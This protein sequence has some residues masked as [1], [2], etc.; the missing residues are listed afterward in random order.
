MLCLAQ[1]KCNTTIISNRKDVLGNHPNLRFFGTDLNEAGSV[2]LLGITISKDLS[3]N[4]VINRMA[5]SAGQRLGLL[6][7]TAPYLSPPQRATIYKSMVRSKMEYAST[8]WCNATSTSLAQLD[9]VQ[10]RA[11]RIIGLREGEF[12]AQQILPITSSED[13]WSRGWSMYYVSIVWLTGRLPMFYVTCC[14]THLFMSHD[15]AAEVQGQIWWNTKNRSFPQLL[16]SWFLF[17]GKSQELPLRHPS[18]DARY[19]I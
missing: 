11:K 9:R 14:P 17:Q 16:R 1:P 6:R 3:W 13:C 5:K 10:N 8:A 4:P 2:D 7:R 12:N 15:P 18:E 19:T